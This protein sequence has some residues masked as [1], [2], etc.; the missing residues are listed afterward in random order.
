MF[1]KIKTVYPLTEYRLSVQF[2]DGCTK[3]YYVKPLLESIPV[4]AK[5]IDFNLFS[6]V[7]VDVGGQGVIWDDDL[8]LSCEE[9]LGNGVKA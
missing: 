3:I 9:L 6:D 2:S 4:F 5:L 1:H 7:R 8:D